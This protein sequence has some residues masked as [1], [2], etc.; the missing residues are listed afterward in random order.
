[1]EPLLGCGGHGQLS[2]IA[3][4]ETIITDKIVGIIIVFYKVHIPKAIKYVRECNNLILKLFITSLFYMV[5]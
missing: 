1:M 3:R 5:T 4:K 2:Y